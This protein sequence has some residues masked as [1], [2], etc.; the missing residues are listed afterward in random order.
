MSHISKNQKLNGTFTDFVSKIPSPENTADSIYHQPDLWEFFWALNP[1]L[2]SKSAPSILSPTNSN[3]VPNFS[4]QNPP[5]I[6]IQ[7][8][9]TLNSLVRGNPSPPNL[10]PQNPTSNSKFPTQPTTFSPPTSPTQNL[11][12]NSNFQ[13]EPR[14]I[15]SPLT[16]LHNPSTESP[17]NPKQIPPLLSALSP[18]F[19]FDLCL[20]QQFSNSSGSLAIP[21]VSSTHDSVPSESQHQQVKAAGGDS[22]QQQLNVY[23]RKKFKTRHN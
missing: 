1:L 3:Y 20:Y 16:Q 2:T 11:T 17:S 23:S 5:Q 22:T 4:P 7:S 15:F 8:S 14:P 9:T 21:S 10:S 19:F 12:S 18:D 6:L 13:T